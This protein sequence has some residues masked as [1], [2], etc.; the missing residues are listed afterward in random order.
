MIGRTRQFIA[1]HVQHAPR[2]ADAYSSANARTA[3]TVMPL[4]LGVLPLSHRLP[5]MDMPSSAAA[6]PARLGLRWRCPASQ[7]SLRSA[8]LA[9]QPPCPLWPRS[10]WPLP[11]EPEAPAKS[12]L[13]GSPADADTSATAAAKFLVDAAAPILLLLLLGAKAPA[14]LLGLRLVSAPAGG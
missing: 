2:N 4:N 6:V 8:A 10:P 13:P 7:L 1:S 9:L 11:S 14:P 3:A 5:V 12:R